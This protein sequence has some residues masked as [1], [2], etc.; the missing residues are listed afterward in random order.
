MQQPPT[1][2][3]PKLGT[4]EDPPAH[5]AAAE[6]QRRARERS[7]IL[8]EPAGTPSGTDGSD[9]SERDDPIHEHVPDDGKDHWRR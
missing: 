4:P 8:G 3:G 2:S 9:G 5:E 7:G 1:D 6:P